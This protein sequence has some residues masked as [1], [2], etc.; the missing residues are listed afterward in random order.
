[1][2]ARLVV[3]EVERHGIDRRAEAHLQEARIVTPVGQAMVARECALDREIVEHLQATAVRIIKGHA[4]RYE[5]V[6]LGTRCVALKID[7][8]CMGETEREHRCC[9]HG[10]KPSFEISFM[11]ILVLGLEANKILQSNRRALKFTFSVFSELE[12]ET[13]SY[14]W[15]M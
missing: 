2:K 3:A 8:R 13:S 10:G 14:S 12:E 5:S 11:T 1:M 9:G 6:R 4:S 7:N 15:L